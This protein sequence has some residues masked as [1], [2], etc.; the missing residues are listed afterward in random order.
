[1]TFDRPQRNGADLPQAPALAA[2][3]RALDLFSCAGGATLGLK[4]AGFHVVGVDFYHQPNYCGDAFLRADALEYL[5]TASLDCFDFIWASPPCQRFTALRHAPGTK[6]HL[7]L[8]APTRALLER[9]SKPYCIENVVGAPLINPTTLCGSMFALKTPDG[10]EL[11]RHRLFET[12]FPLLTPP[13]T[14]GKG[15]IVGVYG[16]HVRDRRRPSGT[17]HKSG[18]NLPWEHAFVAMGVPVGSMTLAELSEAIPPAYSRFVA[19][20]FLR[21]GERPTGSPAPAP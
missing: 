2:Q 19:E 3:M 1:M 11:R 8:I 10:A 14:H 21:C 9:S 17:N 13:C 12:S 20:A 18:S 7:D 16:A 5:A 15:P 4:Q 6:T